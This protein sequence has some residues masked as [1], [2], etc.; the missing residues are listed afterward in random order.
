MKKKLGKIIIIIVI[1]IIIF[2]ITN[3]IFGIKILKEAYDYCQ[4]CNSQGNLN[5]YSCIYVQYGDSNNKY[6]RT[7]KYFKNGNTYTQNYYA[8]EQGC[9]YIEAYNDVE[10]EDYLLMSMVN[11][12]PNTIVYEIIDFAFS[13]K[14]VIPLSRTVVTMSSFE[15]MNLFEKLNLFFNL[16]GF[17]YLE[18]VDDKWC[19]VINMIDSTSFIIDENGN[20]IPDRYKV[21]LDVKNLLPIKESYLV[22][23]EY[24]ESEY[25]TYDFKFD[26]VTD[27]DVAWP[28]LAGK[29]LKINEIN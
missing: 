28:D 27:E 19:Y 24:G 13:D 1:F 10:T 21:W 17:T 20:E 7:E 14:I 22:D 4:E 29:N 6:Q 25:I 2:F 18:K 26:V 5:L 11:N 12:D 16:N 9:T 23:E 8:S 15:T 3:K